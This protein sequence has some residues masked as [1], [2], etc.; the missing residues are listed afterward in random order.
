MNFLL[1]DSFIPIKD[2]NFE[3]SSGLSLFS[4]SIFFRFFGGDGGGE[5]GDGGSAGV[6]NGCL[7]EAAQQ[8]SV[9]G[10]L[11]ETVAEEVNNERVAA[12][13]ALIPDR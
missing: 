10:Q 6:V 2:F 12:M 1:F 9:L 11:P 4:G 13:S 5:P 3:G 7:G 8:Q